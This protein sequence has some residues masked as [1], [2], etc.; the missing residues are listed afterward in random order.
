MIL[1]ELIEALDKA[2]NEHGADA[3]LPIGFHRPHSYRGYYD[4][5]AFE[6]KEQA[7]LGDMLYEARMAHGATF[8]GYKGGSY[9]MGDYTECWLAEWDSTGETIGPLLLDYMLRDV[10]K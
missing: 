5:V 4:D 8:T 3:I 6:T 1:K 10:K 7:R 9:T 2:V